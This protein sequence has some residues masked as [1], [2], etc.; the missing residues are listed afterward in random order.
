[1]CLTVYNRNYVTFPLVIYVKFWRIG[2]Y[3]NLTYEEN[4]SLLLTLL[5]LSTYYQQSIAF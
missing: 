2:F 5:A 1:M 4:Y 3:L